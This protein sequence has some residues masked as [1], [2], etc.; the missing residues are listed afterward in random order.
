[1]IQIGIV[2]VYRFQY[3]RSEMDEKIKDDQV[4][5]ASTKNSNPELP[6]DER[7]D[8]VGAL[9]RSFSGGFK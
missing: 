6:V 8:F 1:M 3:R 5:A 2:G 9:A 7:L 4:V